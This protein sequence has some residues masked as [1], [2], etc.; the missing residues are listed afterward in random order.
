MDSSD[1]DTLNGPVLHDDYPTTGT[2]IWQPSTPPPR[3]PPTEEQQFYITQA[4]TL[5]KVLN[6]VTHR[7]KVKIQIKIPRIPV[8]RIQCINA[9]FLAGSPNLTT[10]RVLTL[11]PLVL[12]FPEPI[13]IPQPNGQV[14]L[15]TQIT[16]PI[17]TPIMFRMER[18]KWT[19]P[20]QKRSNRSP[21]MFWTYY[22]A[23]SSWKLIV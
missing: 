7:R 14:N 4:Q 3:R 5:A 12:D 8:S 23:S 2:D 9:R 17:H 21:Y 11:E 16:I 20:P 6:E 15:A 10:L 18:L 19:D 13:C 22:L 1:R